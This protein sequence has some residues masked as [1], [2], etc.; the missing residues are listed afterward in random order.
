MKSSKCI[1]IDASI[2]KSAGETQHPVSSA[3][4]DFLLAILKICHRVVLN[5][6]ITGEWDKHQSYFS[7]KW[8]STMI[9]KKK[10][11]FIDCDNIISD[12]HIEASSHCAEPKKRAS[13]KDC[14]LINSALLA[15]GI[16]ASLDEKAR[17]AFIELSKDI[18]KI[19]SVAWVNPVLEQLDTWLEAGAEVTGRTLGPE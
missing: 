1:V 3:C 12:E 5:K 9:A 10:V 16:V 11:C 13:K 19:R 2:A 18:R 17:A 8:R 14:F 4:R 15:D 7:L 6:D